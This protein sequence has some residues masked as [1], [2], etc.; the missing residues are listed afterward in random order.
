MFI[1]NT[2]TRLT[3]NPFEDT[4]VSSVSLNAVHSS[5]NKKMQTGRMLLLTA[6]NLIRWQIF[7]DF[8]NNWETWDHAENMFVGWWI[9]GT[10]SK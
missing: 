10:G 8:A 3:F 9:Q 6:V 5:D 1:R 2:G 4:F 7:E